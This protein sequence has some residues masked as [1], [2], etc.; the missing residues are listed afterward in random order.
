LPTTKAISF[1][2]RS[3]AEL[4]SLFEDFRLMCNDAIRIAI[5]YEKEHDGQRAESRFRL[6]ELA[7]RRLKE[8][9][10][11][12][13]YILLACEV[14]YTA[15]RDK[16][17]KVDPYVRRAFLKLDSRAY[18]LEHLVL[19][20]PTRPRRFLFLTLQASDYHLSLIDDPTLKRGSVTVTNRTVNIAFSKQI[21]KIEPRGRIGIDVNEKN[22]TWS[23]SSGTMNREDT[24]EIVELKE[25]YREIRAKIARRTKNDMRVQRRLLSRYGKRDKDRTIQLIHR[26]SKK[27]VKHAKDNRFGI[28]MEKL[29]GIGDTITRGTV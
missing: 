3:S 8:Y 13:H 16:R 19:R 1:S 2:Y 27:I 22:I 18:S 14:A 4:S 11:H 29:N 25:R 10:L 26:V 6:I 9:G 5:R 23:D 12:S 7:Y 28:V 15:Y 21:A 24:S 20:I 17:R